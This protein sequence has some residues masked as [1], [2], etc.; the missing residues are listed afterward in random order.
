MITA[1]NLSGPYKW[2]MSVR[3]EDS[4]A[5]LLHFYMSTCADSKLDCVLMSFGTM[6]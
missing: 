3:G 1:L 5:I 2:Y 6:S 4:T